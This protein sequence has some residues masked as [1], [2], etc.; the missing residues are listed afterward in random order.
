MTKYPDQSD[1]AALERMHCLRTTYIDQ[2]IPR[3]N[4][5]R[6][7]KYLIPKLNAEDA[8][9]AM[10]Y[11]GMVYLQGDPEQGKKLTK[12]GYKPKPKKVLQWMEKAFET[13]PVGSREHHRLCKCLMLWHRQNLRDEKTAEYYEGLM[14]EA[15]KPPKGSQLQKLVFELANLNKTVSLETGGTPK[16]LKPIVKKLGSK[17]PA[18]HRSR[19]KGLSGS[20]ATYL[21]ECV[22]KESFGL[23][24]DHVVMSNA[25]GIAGLAKLIGPIIQLGFFPIADV[26]G[27]IVVCSM[28]DDHVYELD[29]SEAETEEEVVFNSTDMGKLLRLLKDSLKDMK[30]MKK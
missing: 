7:F 28:H 24:Y 27:H 6:R 13:A 5:I 14:N 20:L 8:A 29:C 2:E 21:M 3:R 23:A 12:L 15:K 30:A 9:N 4:V 17:L 26:N 22:P 19:V 1:Q 25:S 18:K 11:L 10:Y 16:V